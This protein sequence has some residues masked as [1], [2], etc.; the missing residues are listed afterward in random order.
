MVPFPLQQRL[1]EIA[2]MPSY[3]YIAYLVYTEICLV[4]ECHDHL[5]HAADK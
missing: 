3:R 1:R 2:K 4:K 5:L